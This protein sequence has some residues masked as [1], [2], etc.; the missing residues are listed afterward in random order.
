MPATSISTTG[1]FNL[2]I[3]Y[4][5]S[6]SQAEFI[7]I[8]VL[9]P[10]G[11]KA[12]ST[13]HGSCDCGNIQYE[14]QDEP[15]NTVFCYCRTCQ[16]HTNSDKWFGVWVPF[17]KFKLVKGTPSSFT[18]L[19][20]SG[21]ETHRLFCGNCSTVLGLK[22]DGFDLYSLSASTIAGGDKLLPKMLIYT[23]VAPAWATFPAGI[24]KYDILPPG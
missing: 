21:S 16:L 15:V 8:P 17:D 14:F 7:I 2:S 3:S 12:M 19:G 24:P 5:P 13:Y 4:F 23:S 10:E 6:V 18:A 11:V 20:D 9:Y 22:C 1:I